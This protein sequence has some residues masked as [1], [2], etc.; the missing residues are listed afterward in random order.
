M[1]NI[2]QGGTLFD[3]FACLAGQPLQTGVFSAALALVLGSVAVLSMQQESKKAKST[4]KVALPTGSEAQFARDERLRERAR[5][6]YGMPPLGDSIR[7]GVAI[8]ATAPSAA[9]SWAPSAATSSAPSAMPMAMA[10]AMED[11]TAEGCE[12]AAAIFM[13]SEA[14]NMAPSAAT[15]S[16]EAADSTSR[17]P[18]SA[19]TCSYRIGTAQQLRAAQESLRSG[20][21]PPTNRDL[22]A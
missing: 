6:C 5:E 18:A 22:C 12:E 9:T 20:S 21:A 17:R 7:G 13:Q 19:P 3:E 15:G 16:N 14:L 1:F 10:M 8:G 11:S 4:L 2:V